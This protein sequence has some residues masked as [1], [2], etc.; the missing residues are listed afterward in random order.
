ML[1]SP[2]VAEFH[3]LGIGEPH[4]VS[5]AHGQGIRSLADAALALLEL[6]DEPEEEADDGTDRPIRLAVA[7]RPNVGKSTLIN[8]WLGEERLI[9]FD[10]PGTTRDAI[11]VPFERAG[12]RF[13]LIDTAG[14]RRKGKV[15]EAIEKFSVVKTLQAIADANVVVL[16]VDA[17]QG[18]SEQDAHIAGYI[19]DSG[20]AVVVAVNKW[21]AV[22]AYQREM[23]DRSVQQRL[24]FLRFAEVL[25][26]SAK[27]RA[28]LGPLWK[29]I[30]AA[31]ASATCKMSTPVLTRLVHDAVAHQAPKRAGM[32]RPKLRYAH[33]GGMN[34][35]IV[36]VHGNAL[37]HVT[38]VYKRFLEGRIRE[39]FKLVGTPLRVEMKA[40]RNPFDKNAD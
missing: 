25:H 40:S 7:G 34:P 26:I 2:Q 29:A 23:F 30:A 6:P 16:M 33:Q 18:V 22:D 38:D 24:A 39:H 5:A 17:T 15:F 11:H 13:E 8:A 36:V 12:Q 10:Q 3:E 19:L 27:K 9:A 4:P 1:D 21:D 31:H 35:P 28:G 20:R 14:L 32:F 37:E